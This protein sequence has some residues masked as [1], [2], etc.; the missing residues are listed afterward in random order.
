[1]KLYHGTNIDFTDINLSVCRPNKDFGQ[2]FYLTEIKRQALLMA[3]RRCAFI[4]KGTPIVQ[5]YDFN[6][7]FLSSQ[8]LNVKIFDGVSKEW[9]QFIYDNRLGKKR[10]EREYDIVVGPVADDGV[11]YQ[12]N[13]F[14]QQLI[15]IEQLVRELT[16]KK[17]NNQYCFLTGEAIATLQ[18]V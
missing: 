3:I 2:G 10:K 17:L 13:L 6:E 9:A 15:T 16:Y 4:Q 14:R 7:T 12:L 1:M 11:V 8:S 5:T 18:R